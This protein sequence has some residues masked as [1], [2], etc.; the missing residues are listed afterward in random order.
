MQPRNVI[1]TIVSSSGKSMQSISLAIG[2]TRT[3]INSTIQNRSI[4]HVDTVA[5]VADVCGYDLLLRK[6]DDG[7]EIIIDPPQKE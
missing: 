1:P 2:R 3:Y 4:S 6:R 5:A 7:T